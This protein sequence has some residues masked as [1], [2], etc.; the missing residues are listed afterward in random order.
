MKII[1]LF[2]II[3]ISKIKYFYKPSFSLDYNT[4]IIYF[5]YMNKTDIYSFIRKNSNSN[6]IIPKEYNDNLLLLE[7]PAL[8]ETGFVSHCFST[9]LGGISK[10]IYSSM[11]LSYTRGDAE[12]NVTENFKRIAKAKG[13]N[14]ENMVLSD[15]THTTNVK[16][17]TK[18]D[19]GKGIISKRDYSDIDGMITNEKGIVLVTIY[20]DCVP[21]YFVDVEN[22]AIGLA[23][24]GWKGTVNRIGKEI[25]N[26][27]KKNYNTNPENLICAIAPSICKDCYEVGEEVATAFEH[28]FKD[29]IKEILIEKE[30]SCK[31][32]KFFLDLWKANEFVLINAGV[33]KENISTTNICTCCNKDLLFSHR[34][35]K[36]KRGNLAAFLSIN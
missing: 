24:S 2:G 5:K 23:H 28:E 36:G 32:R 20:A 21:L 18:A 35:S 1:S 29:N 19:A 27:M 33:K 10:G 6:I 12:Q 22:R 15:Q 11:N 30:S 4:L 26:A 9:R 16:V 31:E 34:A 17:I 3:I 7:F 13:W 14:I 8:D 25:I